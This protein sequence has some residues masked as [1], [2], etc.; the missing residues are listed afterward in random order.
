MDLNELNR[1]ARALLTA[2]G[3]GRLKFELNNGKKNIATCY[4]VWT[5]GDDNRRI[6]V[7]TRITFSRHWGAVMDEEDCRNVMLHE[8]AHALT[9]GHNHDWVFKAKCR[10]LGTPASETCYRPKA[11]IE[12]AWIA[13]CP[14][15]G[16]KVASMHRAPRK[17]RTCKCHRGVPRWKKNGQEQPICAMPTEYQAA[18]KWFVQR[19]EIS[20]A[21]QNGE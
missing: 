14:V 6:A 5:Y 15:T 10:E 3:L 1:Q 21:L 18:V 16:K 8:I 20:A 7:P 17:L 9:M 2:H 13:F 12:F 11:S 4:G 19:Q